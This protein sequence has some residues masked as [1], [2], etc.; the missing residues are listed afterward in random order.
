MSALRLTYFLCLSALAILLVPIC[1]AQQQ[2]TGIDT[3]VELDDV[4]LN[5]RTITIASKKM[6]AVFVGRLNDSNNK[7]EGTWRQAGREFPLVLDRA[8]RAPERLR[9]QTPRPPFSYQV[10][11]VGFPHQTGK[12]NLAGTLTIPKAEGLAAIPIRRRFRF[13]FRLVNAVSCSSKFHRIG[14]AGCLVSPVQG[15]RGIQRSTAVIHRRERGKEHRSSSRNAHRPWF[16]C[17]LLAYGY[18]PNPVRN[19]P[20]GQTLRLVCELLPMVLFQKGSFRTTI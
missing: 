13:A 9:P 4:A 5:G 16:V 18:R 3:Q 8:T 14:S 7:I 20:G 2:N 1:S 11:E 12:L 10:E 6:K 15:K 19:S 17:V